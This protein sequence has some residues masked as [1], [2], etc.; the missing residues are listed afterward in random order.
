MAENKWIRLDQR[1]WEEGLAETI[2]LAQRL[3]MSGV[4]LVDDRPVTKPGSL[5]PIHARL[6]TKQ[7]T[8]P[9]VSRGGLKLAHA[10][11]HWS[12]SLEGASCLDV[13]AST[14]GFT[15]VLLH[16]GARQVIAMDVG[17][18]QLDWKV[19]SDPRVVIMDRFN[20]RNLQ[21]EDIPEGVDFVVV[22]VSFIALARTI[23]PLLTVLK[24]GGRGVLLIKPQFELPPDQ[25][26]PG[27]VVG[28]DAARHHAVKAVTEHCTAAG[29]DVIGITPSPITGSKG[30]QE[31][32]LY[33]SFS[34]KSQSS[35]DLPPDECRSP[36][37][38]TTEGIQ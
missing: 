7:K 2:D 13:G 33:F 5:V 12:L 19:A 35:A 10:I 38:S 30:N 22:D 18:G 28:D 14:G 21:P 29:M 6:R 34:P 16:H 36:G 32:L 20:V 15:Q 1:V 9:W 26:A 3:I 25:I 31:Y 37:E 17:Y 23:P 11:A 4:I 8:I 27:G 24:P